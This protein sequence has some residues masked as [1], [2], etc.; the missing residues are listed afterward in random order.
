VLLALLQNNLLED[1]A[2]VPPVFLGDIPNISRTFGTGSHAYDL[3]AYFSLADSYAIAPSIEAGWSFDTNT[4]ELVVDTDG[5]GTFGPF[6]V[7][8]SNANG[9]TDSNEF[10]VVVS[11]QAAQESSGGWLFLNMYEAE[12]Q[13]RKALEKRRK[14]L[15]EETERIQDSVDREIATLLREQEAK[16]AKREEY[17]R[18]AQIAKANADLDAARAY[19]ERVAKAYA[20]VITQGNYSAIEALDRELKRAREEEEFILLAL[21]M[22]AG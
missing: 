15:E 18:L 6:T 20:R 19:S 7:T 11:Q 17:E 10:S 22:L 16:D 8:A 13:R 14:E 5:L 4:G 1:A 12:Q 9:D 3:G 21:M 2:E